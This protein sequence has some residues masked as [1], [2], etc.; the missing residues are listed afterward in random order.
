[1]TG[2]L[3][4]LVGVPLV[5][6]TP[7]LLTVPAVVIGSASASTWSGAVLAR[8]LSGGTVP[9]IACWT[10]IDTSPAGPGSRGR[11]PEGGGRPESADTD[12]LTTRM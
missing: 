7:I 9:P 12:K 8:P 5:A 2:A 4:L 6:A 10:T 3:E 11:G 1:M